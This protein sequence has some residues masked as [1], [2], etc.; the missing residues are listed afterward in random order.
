[1]KINFKF[2]IENR[3]KNKT[4]KNYTYLNKKKFQEHDYCKFNRKS[5]DHQRNNNNSIEI[6]F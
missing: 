3:L 6:S 4:I 5:S 2:F 1:M